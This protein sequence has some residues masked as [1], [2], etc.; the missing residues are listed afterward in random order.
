ME[1][2]FHFIFEIVKISLLGCLYATLSVK[3]FSRI[4]THKPKSWVTKL[5]QKQLWWISGFIISVFLFFFMF[6]Y[7]GN[8]GLGDSA[9][10]PIGNFKTVRQ[11][12]GTSTYIEEDNGESIGIESFTVKDS[13]LFAELDDYT[14]KGTYIIW[15]L[16]SDKWYF[17]QTK[18][19][20][21]KLAKQK[22]YPLPDTF[23]D[24][25]YHYSDY[26]HGWRFFLL[27]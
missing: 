24:F 22:K 26:W 27:P 23:K 16:E 21:L 17:Y 10:V 12:N 4:A 3:I 13:K 14:D 18:N 7:W 2:L 20:Y 6:T 5:T 25:Q 1:S 11:I 9:R 15:N 19:E 8:H